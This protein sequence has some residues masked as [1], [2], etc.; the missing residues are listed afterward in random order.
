MVFFMIKS[1]QQKS[2]KSVYEIRY[3]FENIKTYEF[4]PQFST[5]L[6]ADSDALANAQTVDVINNRQR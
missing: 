5:P 6:L 1:L 4:R 3:F 2:H